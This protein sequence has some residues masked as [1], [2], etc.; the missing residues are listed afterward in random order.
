MSFYNRLRELCESNGFPVSYLSQNIP[1]LN[2]SPATIS[3][4]KKGSAPRTETVKKIADYFGVTPEYLLGAE[5]GHA[6]F[7]ASVKIG[8][9]NVIGDNNTVTTNSEQEQAILDIFKK[10]DIYK[11]AELLLY[12]RKLEQES[13]Q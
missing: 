9:G 5:S 2:A 7:S 1:D 13:D 12:A 10:L 11:Q 8:D 3:F 6:S 4:W